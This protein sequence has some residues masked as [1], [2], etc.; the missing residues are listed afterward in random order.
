[1]SGYYGVTKNKWSS[2]VNL[3][4]VIYKMSDLENEYNLENRCVTFEEWNKAN[5]EKGLTTISKIRN[6]YMYVVEDDNRPIYYLNKDEFRKA[7]NKIYKRNYY[8]KYYSGGRKRSKVD[9]K[10]RRAYNKKYYTNNKEKIN[11]KSREYY[12]KMKDVRKARLDRINELEKQLKRSEPV[13][14]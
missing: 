14:V 2:R 5:I 8:R 11:Q 7:R 12:Q 13:L 3:I 9:P 4:S 6:H 1:M 10:K